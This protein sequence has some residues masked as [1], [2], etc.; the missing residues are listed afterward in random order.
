MKN[1]DKYIKNAMR[2]YEDGMPIDEA[3]DKAIAVD[4]LGEDLIDRIGE[5]GPAVINFTR[6]VN[7]YLNLRLKLNEH[8]N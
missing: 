1:H 2:Y 7:N 8:S 3:V 5:D 6:I 4:L